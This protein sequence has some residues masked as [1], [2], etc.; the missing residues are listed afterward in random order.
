MIS[1]TMSVSHLRLRVGSLIPFVQYDV[2]RNDGCG[3]RE[4]RIKRS[5]SQKYLQEQRAY[6]SF[7]ISP[8][9]NRCAVPNPSPLDRLLSNGEYSVLSNVF[10][11]PTP[12]VGITSF[13]GPKNKLIEPKGKKQST[14]IKKKTKKTQRCT[15]KMFASFL[16]IREHYFEKL[17]GEICIKKEEISRLKQ[18]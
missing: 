17:E 15:K 13:H 7:F 1:T 14:W 2:R 16:S 11:K 6:I 3:L 8:F 10:A 12:K 18:V 5:Q 9:V 4:Q